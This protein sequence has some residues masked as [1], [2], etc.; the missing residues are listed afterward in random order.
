M[1]HDPENDIIIVT[2]FSLD[3]PKQFAIEDNNIQKACEVAQS[4]IFEQFIRHNEN[5][6]IPNV[7]VK[8]AYYKLGIDLEVH[9]EAL[10]Y[11]N[12]QNEMSD[13]E[14]VN[15]VKNDE[16][17]AIKIEVDENDIDI[18]FNMINDGANKGHDLRYDLNKLA[19]TNNTKLIQKNRLLKT[20]FNYKRINRDIGLRIP[21]IG[22]NVV[23]VFYNTNYS[24]LNSN[25]ENPSAVG[26][27]NELQGKFIAVVDNS[28]SGSNIEQLLHL[29]DYYKNNINNNLLEILDDDNYVE[30]MFSELAQ[31]N[32]EI[33]DNIKKVL[34]GKNNIQ[35]IKVFTSY[36]DAESYIINSVAVNTIIPISKYKRFIANYSEFYKKTV[37]ELIIYYQERSHNFLNKWLQNN[38][39]VIRNA[40]QY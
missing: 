4:F 17:K 7:E 13:S 14:E 5:N 20:A 26:I 25:I 37:V 32:I 23:S 3:Q 15:I 16:F 36:G 19:S 40:S 38:S 29:F 39:N 9:W 2:G 24:N 35:N 34:S 31:H 21:D 22:D 1:S 6:T 18:I 33:D 10:I 12:Q 8:D 11:Q 30:K 27:I 28:L